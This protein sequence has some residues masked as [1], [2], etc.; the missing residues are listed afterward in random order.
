MEPSELC[1]I[2]LV[3]M[4]ACKGVHR[5]HMAELLNGCNLITQKVHLDHWLA[6]KFA[7]A[8]I[9][10]CIFPCCQLGVLSVVYIGRMSL[11]R[12]LYIEISI[13]ISKNMMMQPTEAVVDI[14]M[15]PPYVPNMGCVESSA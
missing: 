7:I 6:S 10:Q 13:Y 5:T 1:D 15:E 8:N 3:V 12:D 4:H 2:N 9:V 14:G 11:Y